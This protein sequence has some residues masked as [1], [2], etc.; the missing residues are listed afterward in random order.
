MPKITMPSAFF[1]AATLK[2]SGEQVLTV[3]ECRYENV[4][5][6]DKPE[7]MKWVLHFE[8]TTSGVVLS[9]TRL[10]QMV[11][12]FGTNESEA[13]HGKKVTVY[14]DPDVRFAGKK[15]GGV[16]IKAAPVAKSAPASP[17]VMTWPGKDDYEGLLMSQVPTEHLQQFLHD[18]PQADLQLRKAIRLEL[19]DREE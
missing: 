12:L 14:C 7:D 19:A 2:D 17:S 5:P 16:A 9:S 3:K 6:E 1:N 8:E 4:A 15:V 10:D 13:W 11:S 18:Y